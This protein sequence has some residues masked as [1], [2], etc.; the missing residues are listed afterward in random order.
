M[1]NFEDKIVQSM[2]KKILESIYEP[3]FLES[4]HGFRPNKGCHTA[5]KALRQH[6]FRQKVDT[7]IDVDL[8][9]YLGTISHSKMLEFLSH[10][11][12]DK[13]FLRYIHRMLKSGV[14][15]EGDLRVTSEGTAQGSVVSLILSNIFRHYAIDLWFERIVKR[16][17]KGSVELFSYA[18]DLVICCELESDAKRVHAALDKRLEKFSLK[19]N[20]DKTKLVRFSKNKLYFQ[21][22]K[23]E[24]FDFLGF[25]FVLGKSKTGNVIPKLITSRKRFRSK[26][27]NVTIWLKR[28]N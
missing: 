11:I 21:G 20:K 19:M 22:I 5:V 4:S 25:T 24:T 10:K 1:S 23:Q 14:L 15:S 3:L 17:A 13:T 18:D 27:K 12:K 9:N 6:L 2:T 7:V 8:E 28:F 16:H 26:L